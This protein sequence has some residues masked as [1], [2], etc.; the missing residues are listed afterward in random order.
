LNLSHPICN[1]RR[2]LDRAR[3]DLSREIEIQGIQ[4]AHTGLG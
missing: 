3:L 2:R 1:Q 4:I